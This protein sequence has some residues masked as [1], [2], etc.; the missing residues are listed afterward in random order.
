MK[1]RDNDREAL[2]TNEVR[3]VWKLMEQRT[4][5]TVSDLWKLIGKRTN[6]INRP[7]E[8]LNESGPESLIVACVPSLG[9]L[10]VRLGTVPDNDRDHSLPRVLFRR[11]ARTSSHG[12][13]AA[14]LASRSASRSSR[15]SRCQSG[16]AT[17]SSLAAIRSQS[18]WTYSICSSML[19]SSKPGGGTGKA[20]PMIRSN[21][22]CRREFGAS[23]NVSA[24]PR[25][26]RGLRSDVAFFRAWLVGC[27][28]LILIQPSPCSHSL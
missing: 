19:S 6:A 27:G 3:G 11:S 28:A 18:A 5:Y 12:R 8:F 15:I 26:T 16:T 9:L 25:A 4:A 7:R 23:G 1:N 21:L 14:G 10:D 2:T 24:Q 22:A 13:L 17:R 20:I